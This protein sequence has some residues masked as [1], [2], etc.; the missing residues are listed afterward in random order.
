[1][2][3]LDNE[4]RKSITPKMALDLLKEGNERFVNIRTNDRQL[5]DHIAL[6]GIHI[7]ADALP[8]T[9]QKQIAHVIIRIRLP[10][11]V[12]PALI[13]RPIQPARFDPRQK[14]HIR[15][16]IDGTPYRLRLR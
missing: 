5:V 6:F 2:V 10:Q 15:K 12:G 13:I 11:F 1:M 14:E 8:R 4:T 9:S 3:T 16:T 7:I